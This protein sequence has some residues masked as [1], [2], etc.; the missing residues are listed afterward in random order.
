MNT[1]QIIEQ[2]D[3]EIARL[4]RIKELLIETPRLPG[5]FAGRNHSVATRKKMAEAARAR[6]AKQK[7]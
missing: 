3:A 6:W 4:R 7:S 5:R 1:G 2:L